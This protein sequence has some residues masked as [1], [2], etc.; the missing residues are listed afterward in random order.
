MKT[1]TFL[2]VFGLGL[3]VVAATMIGFAPPL[4]KLLGV[5]LLGVAGI[6]LIGADQPTNQRKGP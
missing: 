4:A 5:A 2:C 1:E 3:L 6:L